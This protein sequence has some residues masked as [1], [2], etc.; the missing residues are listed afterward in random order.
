VAVVAW[1]E[2]MAAEGAVGLLEI[3]V[4]VVVVVVMD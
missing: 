1:I 2:G 3:V 4:V